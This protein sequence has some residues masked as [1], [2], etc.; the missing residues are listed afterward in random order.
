[1]RKLVIAA[2][3]LVVF[4]AACGSSEAS[5][6]ND[7]DVVFVQGMIAHHDQAIL[8]SDMALADSANASTSVTDLAQRIKDAQNPEVNMM[9]NWLSTWDMPMQ[10][11]SNGDSS[12][13]D[14]G[15]SGLMSDS[16]MASMDGKMGSE[17]DKTW[18][19][20]MIKHHQGALDMANAIK[21]D[22]MNSDVMNLAD[23]IISGQSA[24]ITEMEQMLNR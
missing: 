22:G 6:F 11:E 5:K 24:E 14:M 7:A 13:G 17:F 2:M 10:M 19:E 21:Q 15:H 4:L 1:M 16:E 23:Q 18:L 8:M 20:L 3:S 9:T 12:M